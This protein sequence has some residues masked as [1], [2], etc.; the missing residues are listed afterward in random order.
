[1]E[2]FE[3]GLNK[4]FEISFVPEAGG[5]ATHVQKHLSSLWQQEY[6]ESGY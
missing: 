3:Q 4:Y 1:M 6:G 2:N 5:D